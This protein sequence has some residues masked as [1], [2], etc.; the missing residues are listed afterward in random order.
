MQMEF[1]KFMMTSALCDLVL[2]ELCNN[3]IQDNCWKEAYQNGREQGCAIVSSTKSVHISENRNNDSIVV[4]IDNKANQGLTE[5][6]YNNRHY[7]NYG[8]YTEVVKFCVQEF[9]K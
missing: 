9:S 1:G 6:A 4:Y 2:F 3:D 7:F 8:E 5:E